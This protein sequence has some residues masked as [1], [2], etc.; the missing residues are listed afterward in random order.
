MNTLGTG[1][2]EDVEQDHGARF[3]LPGGG[4]GSGNLDYV[5]CNQP[6]AFTGK[7]T[8]AQSGPATWRESHSQEGGEPVFQI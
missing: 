8:K 2:G 1:E 5:R 7:E 3:K 4:E 6:L